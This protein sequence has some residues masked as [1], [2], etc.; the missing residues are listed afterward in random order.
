MT[1]YDCTLQNCKP[2]IGMNDDFQ[3][4]IPLFDGFFEKHALGV[5]PN[6]QN[7]LHAS[8]FYLS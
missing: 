7:G 5:S 3:M 4:R 6:H 8:A 2:C 1:I